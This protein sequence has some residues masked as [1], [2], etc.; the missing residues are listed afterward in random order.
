MTFKLLEQIQPFIT[1]LFCR[2]WNTLPTEVRQLPTLTFFKNHLSQGK[3]NV[4]KHY[5]YGARRAQIL[6]TRLRTGCSSLNLDQFLKN[7]TDSPLCRCGSI[8]NI[9]HYFFD[10]L[11]YEAPRVLLLNSVVIYQTPS[12]NLL[13][14][15]NTTLSQTTNNLIFK[16]VHKFIL[17]TKRF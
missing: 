8:E 17:E 12:I 3:R 1:T 11:F 13:L 15:G 14:Y 5:Y 7:I 10:C 16:H 4:P 6:H 9:H 2:Q